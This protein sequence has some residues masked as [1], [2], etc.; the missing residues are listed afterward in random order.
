ML[1]EKYKRIQVVCQLIDRYLQLFDLFRKECRQ[2][3]F[4]H[5]KKVHNCFHG[6]TKTE[7]NPYI[8]P[9]KEE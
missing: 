4:N 6:G 3:T 2:H 9:L 1:E 7:C 8:C 5:V